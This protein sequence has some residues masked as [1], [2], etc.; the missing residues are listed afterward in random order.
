MSLF[1][2]YKYSTNK[3]KIYR[4][5]VIYLTVELLRKR[6]MLW[7]MQGDIGAI[8]YFLIED[9]KYKYFIILFH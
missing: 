3:E 9:V 6:G 8:V 5:I 1:S 2:P 7:S 4:H